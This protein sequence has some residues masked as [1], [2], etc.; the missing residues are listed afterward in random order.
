MDNFIFGRYLPMDSIIH[1]MNPAAKIFLCFYF[2]I[3]VFFAN[4]LLS[5]S[6]MSLFVIALIF[7][8][9]SPIKMFFK[10]IMPLIWIILFTIAI[11]ILFSSGGETIYKI[12]I[13]NITTF[14]I[15]NAIFLFMRFILIISLST[16]LTITT[17]PLEISSGISILLRPFKKL[18]FPVETFSLMISIALRFVPTL[19]DET[20][21]I[22]DAQ[23]SRGVD[24]GSGGLVKRVK[25]F[26]PLLIPLFVSA[27]KHADNLSIAMESRGYRINNRRTHY[28]NYNWS[29]FDTLSIF[30]AILI[31]MIIFI[32]RK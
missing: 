27:F 25:S 2:V 10:G 31:S 9:K 6:A 24:F 26:I 20:K 30:V 22:M 5:Y 11:Q 15:K 13:I 28:N 7:L 21:T 8:S 19:T 3:L 16:I 12:G 23:R 18:K 29:N 32:L 14:G 4:G 17:D 1:K